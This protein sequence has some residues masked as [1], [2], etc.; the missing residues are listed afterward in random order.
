MVQAF[1]SL[2]RPAPPVSAQH[3]AQQWWWQQWWW[4]VLVGHMRCMLHD[5]QSGRSRTLEV[6]F[7]YAQR[8]LFHFTLEELAS[9][10][11]LFV[12]QIRAE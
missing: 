11:H 3:P 4:E 9:Q 2:S 1:L 6:Q 7:P 10:V 12:A 5:H 8:N